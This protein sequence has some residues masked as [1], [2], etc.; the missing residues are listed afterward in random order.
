M[1]FGDLKDD[2]SIQD[3]IQNFHNSVGKIEKMLERM[4]NTEIREKLT[5]KE[6]VDYDLFM[7]YSLNTLYWLYLRTRGL[8]PNKND[9][10]SQLNRVKEYMIKAKQVS[11]FFCFL[12]SYAL[13]NVF[14]C[15]HMIEI[16]LDQ[17][18]IRKLQNDL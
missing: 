9:V 8:D 1:D 3:K 7:V 11:H 16:Q 10:K 6:K 4:N 14:S 13:F 18:L 2:K 17:Q 5:L 12:S 15:R